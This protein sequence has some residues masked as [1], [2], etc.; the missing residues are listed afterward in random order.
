[1][2]THYCPLMHIR[3]PC[4]LDLP[5]P[6]CR[7]TGKVFG[8]QGSLNPQFGTSLP[9]CMDDLLPTCGLL[10]VMGLNGPTKKE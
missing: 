10:I 8:P 5:L 9:S 7:W 1:M 6:V 3:G 2:N 4:I